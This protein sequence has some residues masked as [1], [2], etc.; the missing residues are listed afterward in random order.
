MP[1]YLLFRNAGMLGYQTH[2]QYFHPIV[3]PELARVIKVDGLWYKDIRCK[4]EPDSH[5]VKYFASTLPRIASDFR[6]RF[7]QNK[8]TLQHFPDNSKLAEIKL[9][10]TTRRRVFAEAWKALA[11]E[12][13]SP[14]LIV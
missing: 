14:D 1:T 3:E 9:H 6:T 11:G 8:A 7:T 12:D 4:L 2:F 5:I 10:P 13:L